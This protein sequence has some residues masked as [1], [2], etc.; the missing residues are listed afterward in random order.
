MRI[1]KLKKPDV[2][3]LV[4]FGADMATAIK[5]AT[6]LGLKEKMQIIVPNLTLGMAEGAGAEAMEGVVGALPWSWQ[7]PEKYG[8]E[9]GKKFVTDFETR[10]GSYPSTS[11]ASA[12]TIMYEYRDA[13]ARAGSSDGASVVKALE[14]HEYELL[15]DK[16]T[17]RA[18]DHQSIQSVFAV[19]CKPAAEVKASKHGQDFFEIISRM[20]GDKAFIDEA[21]WK[22]QRI[23]AGKEPQLQALP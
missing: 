7:V 16:Q 22:E 17:W 12:Y 10:Y 5:E 2:L 14:G 11:G 20:D 23:A 8:Y 19:K 18:L 4:L 15:K 13:V 21:T 9:R 1:A 3:V 6:K